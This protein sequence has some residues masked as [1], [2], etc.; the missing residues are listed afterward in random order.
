MI[1]LKLLKTKTPRDEKTTPFFSE[2]SHRVFYVLCEISDHWERDSFE[3]KWGP[4]WSREIENSSDSSYLE[5]SSEEG[6][7]LCHCDNKDFCSC[8]KTI[9]VLTKSEQ[10]IFELIDK[11]EDPQLNLNI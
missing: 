5:N 2:R 7:K 8:K 1:P 3:G 9:N 11:I 10:I 4:T 6:T